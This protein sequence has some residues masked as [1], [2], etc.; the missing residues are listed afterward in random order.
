MRSG[1]KQCVAVS[2]ICVSFGMSPLQAWSQHE[3]H[4]WL[5]CHASAHRTYTHARTHTSALP[6][7]ILKHTRTRA[8]THLQHMAG[9]KERLALLQALDALQHPR[10]PVDRRERVHLWP[11]IERLVVDGL[12]LDPRDSCV[13]WACAWQHGYKQSVRLSAPG[14]CADPTVQGGSTMASPRDRTWVVW[15]R[16]GSIFDCFASFLRARHGVRSAPRLSSRQMC[17]KH[18]LL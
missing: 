7:Y 18:T 4:V 15:R 8:R 6:A 14:A 3:H 9:E 1:R 2:Y 10:L 5:R 17:C 16:N 12:P 11:H 13:C